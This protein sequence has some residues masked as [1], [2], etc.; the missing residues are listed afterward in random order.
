MTE[1]DVNEERGN[2]YTVHILFSET[3]KKKEERES[4]KP[5]RGLSHGGIRR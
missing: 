3:E 4:P 5:P 2:I 1:R